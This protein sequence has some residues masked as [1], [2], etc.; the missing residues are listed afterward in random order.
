MSRAPL[1]LALALLGLAVQVAVFVV[2]LGESGLDFG[3][4]GE[5]AV[6]TT[7]AILTLTD[8][9]LTGTVV[10]LWMPG[11]AA[12]VGI[13]KWWPFALA[14]VGGVC[15][16]LPLFLWARERRLETASA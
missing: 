2:F 5:Q 1:F 16:A 9:L 3:E 11:E 10:L 8:L 15:F 13:Q 4:L 7:I 14:A 6:E 12:R